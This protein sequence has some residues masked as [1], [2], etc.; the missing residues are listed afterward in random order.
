MSWGFS[1]AFV[2]QASGEEDKEEEEV[3]DRWLGDV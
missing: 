3:V 1:G 2:Q